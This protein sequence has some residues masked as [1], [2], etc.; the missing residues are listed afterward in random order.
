MP[1]NVVEF[2]DQR[3]N[4][5][6]DTRQAGL[7]HCPSQCD[8]AHHAAGALQPA[9]SRLSVRLPARDGSQGRRAGPRRQERISHALETAEIKSFTWHDLR[10]TFASWLLMKGASLRSVAELLGHRGLRMVMRYAHLS[11][12]HLSAEVGLLD[13]TT[14]PPP[15]PTET[16]R[17]ERVFRDQHSRHWHNLQRVRC[18]RVR[19]GFAPVGNVPAQPTGQRRPIHTGRP[20]SLADCSCEVSIVTNRSIRSLA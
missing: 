4:W 15:A 10:H 12:E 9:D 6:F 19:S 11:P 1:C 8:R 20:S 18:D 16:R 5:Q 2:G 14:A 3:E 13:P 7:T 17:S